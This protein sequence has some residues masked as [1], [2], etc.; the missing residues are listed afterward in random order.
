MI[1]YSSLD[2]SWGK[3]FYGYKEK[4]GAKTFVLLTGIASTCKSLQGILV[5][6]S[7]EYSVLSMDNLGA[8][9]SPQPETSFEISDISEILKNILDSKGISKIYLGGISMGGL[10]AQDFSS[11]FPE[12]VEK[13]VI[14]GSHTGGNDYSPP[15]PE[16]RA[17]WTSESKEDL[18]PQ[19]LKYCY[20][21]R[22]IEKWPDIISI[23]IDYWDRELPLQNPKS[24]ALQK[25]AADRFGF[26]PPSDFWY[27]GCTLIMSSREDLILP[28]ENHLALKKRYPHADEIVYEEG[29]HF[30]MFEHKKTFLQQIKEYLKS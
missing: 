3:I 25:A 6:L 23:L 9:F 5:P 14:I 26:A 11:R 29:G 15:K 30:F 21:P 12:K 24:F 10:I 22:A 1:E 18:R 7:K 4:E 2:S 19:R 20:G 28:Y 17:V 13:L 16:V 8:G 27:A